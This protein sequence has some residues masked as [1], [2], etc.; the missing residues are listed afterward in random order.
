[1]QYSFASLEGFASQIL[2]S[3]GLDGG[4]AD[5][6]GKRLVMADAMG[7]HTHGLAYLPIY[8]KALKSGV[9]T[10]AG[11][12]DTLKDTGPILAWHG[13]R[14]SGI[15]LVDKAVKLACG[16]AQ[17]F[18]LCVMTIREAHHTGC[19]ASFLPYI[20][21]AGLLG[22]IAV[23]G[24][25][26]RA[27]VPFG[28]KTPVLTP[29]PFAMCIP[30]QDVPI[31]IDM[32]CSITT[33][34]MAENLHKKGEP[35]PGKWAQD[36]DGCAVDDPAVLFGD[37]KGGLLPVGG[38]D[39]GY[40]GFSLAVMVEALTQG[41]AGYGRADQPSGS[42]TNVYIQ[43]TDPEAFA[44]LEAFKR[45][46]T[47]LVSACQASEPIDAAKPVRLPGMAAMKGLKKAGEHGVLLSRNI[48]EILETMAHD[49]RVDLPPNI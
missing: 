37:P 23:S 46:T 40:K 36:C 20:A 32:S 44:G 27:V 5:V 22:Y 1:M 10:P 33:N 45:Q 41:L 38:E 7:H 15:W 42:Q 25:A 16:R 3:A 9:L 48:I 11:E 29:N 28:G 47:Y 21:Q 12:P 8:V 13:K 18:G 34:T 2:Q 30:T 39:H 35:F 17:K 26:G 6:A 49:H 4:H 43:I 31:L 19:L 24:P 14:L